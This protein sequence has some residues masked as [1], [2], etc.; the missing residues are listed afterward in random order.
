MA[1]KVVLV[2]SGQPTLNPRLVKEADALSNAGYKVTVIYAYWN[3][4]GTKHDE[5]LLP[6]KKWQ[7]V[8]VAGAPVDAK[9]TYFLSRLINFAGRLAVNRSLDRFAEYAISRSTFFLLKEA[10]KHKADLYIAHNLGALPAVVQAAKANNSLC[11][12]DAEDFHRHEISDDLN[13]PDVR[14]KGYIEDKYLPQTNYFTTSSEQI[15]EA[16]RQ[17]YPK[18]KPVVLLN[19]F[20]KGDVRAIKINYHQPVKLLWFSQ[21]IGAN[22]GLDD[23]VDALQRLDPADYELHLLGSTMGNEAFA[24]RLNNSGI[25]IKF[26]H[27]MPADELSLFAAKFDI[28]LALEPGF[29]INNNLALSNKLFTY[30]QA[31]LAII[32]SDTAAQQHFMNKYPHVGRSYSK[33]NAA[34]LA[35]IL[36]AFNTNRSM[37]DACKSEALRLA[38]EQYNWEMESLKFL[39]VVKNTLS[40]KN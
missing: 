15:A 28:G 34:Q 2:S 14:L 5:Q 20:P 22:R 12:F 25:N 7:A 19:V 31:G 23:I 36:T 37:L 18:L 3:D 10:K 9:T 1:K 11:G 13:N 35:T 33:G 24:D 30:M 40:T 6:A 29:S 32:A 21:A 16:Y 4:W 38:H 8:R 27:T 39:D 26:H 17:I